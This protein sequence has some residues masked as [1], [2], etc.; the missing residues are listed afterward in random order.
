MQSSDLPKKY[1]DDKI[2]FWIITV[3]V[4]FSVALAFEN[5]EESNDTALIIR[6]SLEY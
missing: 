5:F 4:R 3:P 1:P 6:Y 2:C